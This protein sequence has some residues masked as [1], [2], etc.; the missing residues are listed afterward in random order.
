MIP[1]VVSSSSIRARRSFAEAT[2]SCRRIAS[3][4]CASTRCTGSSAFIE[5]WKTS[6]TWRQRTK[7]MPRSV[8]RS[9]LIGSASPGG[10][11]T[12]FPVCWSVPGSSFITD[13]A[14]VVF[15]QPDSPAS[16]RASPGSSVRST[17]STIGFAP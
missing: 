12:I 17:P 14:V 7:F 8:R 4:I 9:I 11:R 15:P 10:R 2:R 5:P 13:R 1:T 6:E 3:A 16:P